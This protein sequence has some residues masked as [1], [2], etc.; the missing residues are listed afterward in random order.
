MEHRDTMESYR[1]S[2]WS[3]FSLG[4]IYQCL[5]CRKEEKLYVSSCSCTG[6]PIGDTVNGNNQIK[7][8]FFGG[9][10]KTG[11]P[12]EKALRTDKRTNKLD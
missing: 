1:Q 5:H 9:G 6:A 10:M 2:T 11:V 12:R 4:S 7:R 3:A 8:W